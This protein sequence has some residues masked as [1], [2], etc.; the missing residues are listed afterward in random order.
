V[1]DAVG[2]ALPF[3]VG[4]A[5]SPLPIV[6]IVLILVGRRGVAAGSAF[7]LGV[8][9]GVAALG[10]L[11]LVVVGPRETT[12]DGDPATWVG[13]LQLGLGLVLLVLAV[14]TFRRRPTGE[15]AAELP[16]W[17]TAVGSFS[18]PKAAGAGFLLTVANPKNVVLVL[19]G[20]AAVAETA[21]PAVDQA[22]AW[23]LFAVVGALGA[24][25]PLVVSVVRGERATESLLRLKE[26]MTAN[27]K[28]ILGVLLL[29]IGV[30]LLGDGLSALTS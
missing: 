25:L 13:W 27:Q 9:A 3:A 14:R 4:V 18:P 1:G 20:T 24:G 26:W 21:A 28:A 12:D 2:Q 15:A 29:V 5:L 16:P 30:N 23:A 17:M 6:G 10:A 7:T 11:L 8:F 19:A 22:V